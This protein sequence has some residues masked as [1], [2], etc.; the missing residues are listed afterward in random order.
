MGKSFKYLASLAPKYGYELLMRSQFNTSEIQ[1]AAR[2]ELTITTSA[3]TRVDTF[4]YCLRRNGDKKGVLSKFFFSLKE[5]NDFLTSLKPHGDLCHR[6]LIPMTRLNTCEGDPEGLRNDFKC[7]KCGDIYGCTRS[8]MNLLR[9]KYG[10]NNPTWKPLVSGDPQYFTITSNW[11]RSTINLI[12]NSKDAGPKVLELLISIDNQLDEQAKT[13]RDEM[14][15][16][17]ESGEIAG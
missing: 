9:T 16:L 12:R 15:E 13:W 11:I 7:K 6:C 1:K 3:G 8:S 14:K 4:L 5:V 10:S 2:E 17:I